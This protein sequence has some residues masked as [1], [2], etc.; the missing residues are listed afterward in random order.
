M[1]AGTIS[2]A[3]CVSDTTGE[4]AQ[5]HPG[6]IHDSSLCA[7]ARTRVISAC[8]GDS[9][10]PIVCYKKARKL[11]V[12]EGVLSFGDFTACNKAGVPEVWTRVSFY[13]DWIHELT[14]ECPKP[15]KLPPYVYTTRDPPNGL[16]KHNEPLFCPPGFL[17][18]GADEAICQG[19]GNFTKIGVYAGGA[20]LGVGHRRVQ[21]HLRAR[22]EA[23]RQDV[24]EGR[25][26][27]AA[28]QGVGVRGRRLRDT[29]V[30]TGR[31]LPSDA[32][33]PV[34]ARLLWRR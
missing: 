6:L 3:V 4:G 24:P 23:G 2:R 1:K 17:Q 15:D 10:S 25:L 31:R 11:L 18:T 32:S 21:R 14:T 9:G 22:G 30:L 19:S 28:D 8:Q 5:L 29:E 7:M 20:I 16:F 33:L 12:L 27:P 34:P 13:V 26:N